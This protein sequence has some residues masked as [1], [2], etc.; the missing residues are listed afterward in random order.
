MSSEFYRKY[1]GA[2]DEFAFDQKAAYL[3]R[4]VNIVEPN[5]VFDLNR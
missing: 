3:P 5:Y 4:E 1:H 2:F